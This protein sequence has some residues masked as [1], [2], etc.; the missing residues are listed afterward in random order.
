MAEAPQENIAPGLTLVAGPFSPVA[1]LLSSVCRQVFIICK[2][3]C[4]GNV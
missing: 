4:N 2:H 3:S 1:F